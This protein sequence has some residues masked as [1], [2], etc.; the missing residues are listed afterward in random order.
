[1][2][3]WFIH[4]LP[5]L[6]LKPF[7]MFP[8]YPDFSPACLI[9]VLLRKSRELWND[10]E[11]WMWGQIIFFPRKLDPRSGGIVS[12]TVRAGELVIE[13]GWMDF[14]SLFYIPW[15]QGIP[16][17]SK[18][19]EKGCILFAR[20]IVPRFRVCTCVHTLTTTVDTDGGHHSPHS[21][22]AWASWLSARKW[23][24]RLSSVC[25]SGIV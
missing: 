14:T 17:P 6:G 12:S 1:M 16:Y 24:Q 23:L 25:Q 7:Y 10:R 8:R 4:S 13:N 20:G 22:T 5:S 9:N 18:L 21:R 19:R 15:L 3:C 2:D 11:E